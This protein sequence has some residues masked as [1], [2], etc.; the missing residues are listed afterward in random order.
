[1]PGTR[2]AARDELSAYHDADPIVGEA[3]EHA[4][5]AMGAFEAAQSLDELQV[6]V[7]NPAVAS[8]AL[9]KSR[10]YTPACQALVDEKLIVVNEQFLLEIETAMRAFAQSET[11]F[12]SPFL[13]S[14]AQMFGLVRRISDDP[15]QYRARL[16]R[17]AAA[18]EAVD[19]QLRR[20]LGLVTLFFIGH[21]VGHFMHGHPTGQ[22]ATFLDTSLPLEVRIEDAVVKL[23]R[24]VD[25]FAP[26]QFALPGFDTVA[27]PSSQVRRVVDVLRTRDEPRYSRHELFFTSEAE[28]DDWANHAVLAHLGSLPGEEPQQALHLMAR[29]LF[30]A[31]VYTWYKD[32]DG[33]AR[34]A[35]VRDIGDSRDLDVVMM[36]GRQR[37]IHAASLFGESH[38]FTL[39]RAALALETLLRS[40]TNWFD[41]APAERS[42]WDDEPWLAQ[43]LQRYFLL[44]ACMDTAVKLATVGCSTGWI[45]EADAR[46]GT[47]QMLVMQFYGIDHAVAR[48]KKLR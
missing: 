41:R 39:L 29:G 2:G 3:L 28:A 6:C 13:R 16:R 34:K 40:R 22:F 15:V 30:V 17:Q 27:D 8:S 20:E 14:D 36:Q 10:Y 24:H 31:A 44:C 18:D 23:C 46:R 21:E 5:G 1:M 48:V 35:G 38:R 42:I 43:S 9:L 32:L 12:G 47:D 33:F 11:L 19:R 7:L 26:T 25:E 37:Y 4:L 45:L